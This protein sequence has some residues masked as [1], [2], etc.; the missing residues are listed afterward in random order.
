MPSQPRAKT[1]VSSSFRP[2]IQGLRAVA[3][4]LVVLYHLWP[5]RLTGGFVG[6]DV[7]F[8]LSGFLITGH[9]YRDLARNSRISLSKF[10]GR[11]IRRLLPAAFIVLIAS[12]GAAWIWLPA[13]LWEATAKQIGAS[14][15]YMQ[16]WV[17]AA[18][19]VDYSA[20]NADA[21]V[22][23]H[24]WSLSIEE[25]FYVFWPLFMVG[26]PWL[27]ARLAKLVPGLVVSTR[28]SLIIGLSLVGAATFVYSV[29]MTETDPAAAYFVTPTRVW[30]FVAGALVALIFM[31]RQFSGNVA[32]ILAWMG[33]GSIVFSAVL[34]S[35]QTPFPGY[36]ALMPVLGTVLVL[37]CGG[38]L[39]VWSPTWILSRK[40][41]TFIGDISY[42]V[43]LWHWPLIVL[44][45]FVLGTDLNWINKLGILVLTILLSW[46]TKI[47]IEDPLRKGPLLQGSVRT[48]SF[49]LVGMA[50][51]VTLSTGLVAIANSGPPRNQDLASTPCSGPSALDPASGCNSVLGDSSV[52][53]PFVD[54]ARENRNR[55]FPGCQG[56][57]NGTALVSCDLG[58]PAGS[59]QHTVAIVG[60]SHATTWFPAI[61]KVAKNH[62][63]RVITYSKS[64]CP[65]TTAIRTFKDEKNPQNQD[66]CHTWGASV[67]AAL[68]AND[69]IAAVFTASY[70]STYEYIEGPG[71]PL[72]NPGVDGFTEM[73]AGWQA[74]GKQVVAFNDLPRTNGQN[75]PTCL[76]MNPDSPMKCALPLSEAIP[77]NMVITKAADEW[78][79]KG[80]I[81]IDLQD[82]F[83]DDTWC[84]PVVGSM[85]VYRDYSH[86]SEAYARAL[87]PYIEA[88]LTGLK[89]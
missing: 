56:S 53:L 17:L 39:S 36:T 32:V 29:Y 80:V 24:Y 74:S 41:A 83:C 55:P 30:E 65:V 38:N 22:A 82:K 86:L 37:C 71:Q 77:A 3:V 13:T 60:D 54:V 11:R 63:W 25:Q 85:I 52:A 78:S 75:V 15:L 47:T 84:Y 40:T 34:Y 16:N 8:V 58:V 2:E 87:V 9:I 61:D 31:G 43:Y 12:L 59:A 20:L 6:V 68:K 79:K 1:E 72:S 64:S 81:Q 21:T 73:W 4:I 62:G 27:V 49:T 48:Y 51:I 44:A 50:L 28:K 7:F 46:L 10:W 5:R 76:E 67:D 57:A 35:G 19:A 88:Q 42:A 33:L 70:S 23:Q 89:L 26:F 69:S 14:A 45:P 66:D 18:D